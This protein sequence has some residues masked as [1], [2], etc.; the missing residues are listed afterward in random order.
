NPVT[1]DLKIKSGEVSIAEI[2]RLASAFGVAFAPGATV[3]GRVSTD[4]QAK[5]SF[6]KPILS[7]TIAGRD[8]RI[9]G[10]GIPQPVQVNAVNLAL[11][12]TAIQSNEFNA[13]S[14]KTTVVGKLAVLQ[15]A[16][17]SPSADVELR[18]PG[19]T[20]PEIQSIAKAYGM[21]G[22]DQI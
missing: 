20:L 1:M 13:T 17:S 19:A 18:A 5:G 22:L 21:N 7:G 9:S 10:Q 16:S 8:L 14:G 15:Y 6:A 11:S 2:A 12:P 3:A 4:V